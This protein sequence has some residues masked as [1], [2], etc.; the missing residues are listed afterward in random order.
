MSDQRVSR[1]S[2]SNFVLSRPLFKSQSCLIF[3]L[4][5]ASLFRSSLASLF[6]NN[7]GTFN[8]KNDSIGSGEKKKT[9]YFCRESHYSKISPR[10][11]HSMNLIWTQFMQNCFICIGEHDQI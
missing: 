7:E 6:G 8:E 9:K 3:Q 10:A 4:L 2:E 1:C 5:Q 11:F